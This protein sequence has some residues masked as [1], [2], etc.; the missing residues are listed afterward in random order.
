MDLAVWD[1]DVGPGGVAQQVEDD[2][3][4]A[5]ALQLDFGDKLAQLQNRE[6]PQPQSDDPGLPSTP[7]PP[8]P[9]PL[10]RSSDPQVTGSALPVAPPL[11]LSRRRPSAPAPSSRGTALHVSTPCHTLVCS[12]CSGPMN[13]TW[14]ER[15]DHMLCLDCSLDV[16][17]PANQDLDTPTPPAGPCGAMTLLE[18]NDSF[19]N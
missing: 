6:A 1:V 18:K 3:A 11:S 2:H 13:D 10:L 16:P 5:E 7:S 8:K 12:R 9:S 15:S 14:W 4:F 19:P 17:K